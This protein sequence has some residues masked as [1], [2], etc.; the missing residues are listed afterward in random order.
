MHCPQVYGLSSRQW[1]QVLAAWSGWLLDG[2]TTI[3]YALVAVTIS[4]IMLPPN[5]GKLGLIVTFAGFAVEALARPIGSLLFGNYLGDKIGRR[6]MLAITVLGFSIFGGAKGLLPT[7]GE[8]GLLAPIL[9]YLLLFVEGMFAGAEY[10]GGTA[11]VMESVPPERRGFIGSLIQS[12]F[13]VGY[14][15][16][17]A[18]FAII[19]HAY[20]PIKFQEYGWRI[21]F[22]I[23]FI[24]GALAFLLRRIAYESPV[25][26]DLLR[27][28]A[29]EK[30]PI[31]AMFRESTGKIFTALLIT[32]GLLFI[33]TATL[34]FY[35]GFMEMMKYPNYLVGEYVAIINL[36]SLL[37]VWIGGAL[38]NAVGGRRRSM[39]L[40]SALFTAATG[41]LLIMGSMGPTYA[42]PA[43]SVQAF[44]EA[45]IFSIIP[46][47]LSESFNERYRSTAV[48]FTYNGGAIIGSTAISIILSLSELIGLLP[49]WVI[50]MYLASTIMLIGILASK[51]TWRKN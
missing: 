45:A 24:P 40:Y 29:V 7:Y 51:E 16:M 3:A 9:L 23:L 50:S 13:G 18:I 46:S 1:V 10:G 4:T 22:L 34:S 5:L 15:I 28:Q 14:F 48:G 41:P 30:V 11:L 39:L 38:S 20:G 35:P 37:G 44:L 26:E 49:A 42:L 33:N 32:T 12:G 8:A 27:K 36:A 43:F 19:S 25:F 17:A 6:N 21:L 47:F 31:I 2:F